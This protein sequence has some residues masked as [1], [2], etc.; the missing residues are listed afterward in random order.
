MSAK[1][2]SITGMFSNICD[3]DDVNETVPSFDENIFKV[4]GYDMIADKTPVGD[5]LHTQIA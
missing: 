4:V 1:E 5:Q 3:E 2:V